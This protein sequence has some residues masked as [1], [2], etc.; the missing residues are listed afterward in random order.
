[1]KLLLKMLT[2]RAAAPA[3][4]KQHELVKLPSTRHHKPLNIG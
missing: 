2:L 3:L 1:M 4:I